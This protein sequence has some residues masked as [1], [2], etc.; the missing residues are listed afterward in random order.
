MFV[1]DEIFPLKSYLMR[2]YRTREL[3]TDYKIF[4]CRLSRARRTVKN[5]LCILV[6]QFRIFKKLIITCIPTAV[7]IVKITCV[8][9]NWLQTRS[10]LNYFSPRLIDNEDSEHYSFTS[11]SLRE[12]HKS[13]GLIQLQPL[14]LRF[15]DCSAKDLRNYYRDYFNDIEAVA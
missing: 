8:L 14:P 10:N 12:K 7:K 9:Y 11:G 15:S 2:P 1:G 13:N 6:S 5:A 3:N 4:N